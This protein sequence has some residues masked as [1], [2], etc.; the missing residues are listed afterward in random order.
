MHISSA[1][2]DLQNELTSIVLSSSSGETGS[3]ESLFHSDAAFEDVESAINASQPSAL[4]QVALLRQ[5]IF[6]TGLQKDSVRL[7]RLLKT[8]V[9]SSSDLALA[10]VSYIAEAWPASK[11]TLSPISI[12]FIQMIEFSSS[13]QVRAA[14]V[15]ELSKLLD[16]Y[17]DISLDEHRGLLYELE[18]IVHC[19]AK[20]KSSPQLVNTEV[21]ISGWTHLR[22]FLS[23]TDHEGEALSRLSSKM[24]AWGSLLSLAGD[25]RNVSRLSPTKILAKNNFYRT[26]ILDYRL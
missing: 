15:T 2:V 9:Q 3:R 24:M 12:A 7:W 1:C 14:A 20:G 13:S 5:A 17:F 11:V 6:L 26:L 23:G 19:L 21:A 25:S 18:A 16:S 22:D 8:T 4:L 10:A